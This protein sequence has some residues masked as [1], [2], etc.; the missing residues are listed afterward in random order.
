MA[1]AD[2]LRTANTTMADAATLIENVCSSSGNL[3]FTAWTPTLGTE[4]GMTWTVRSTTCRYAQIGKLVVA[5]FALLGTTGSTG[6]SYVTMTVP[7]TAVGTYPLGFCWVYDVTRGNGFVVG[8]STT[9]AWLLKDGSAN[10]GIGNVDIYGALIY[11]A[12]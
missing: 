9:V 6:K 8:A 4:A 11:E 7:V 2:L 12:A 3:A 1:Y 5:T 10:Y